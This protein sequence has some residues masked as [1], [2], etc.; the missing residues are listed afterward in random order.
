[1]LYKSKQ[2]IQDHQILMSYFP[3]IHIL[4]TCREQND[5]VMDIPVTG[6]RDLE[7]KVHLTTIPIKKKHSLRTFIM[8]SLEKAGVKFFSGTK[9]NYELIMLLISRASTWCGD[10]RVNIKMPSSNIM[11]TLS[12]RG[13]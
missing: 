13:H 2:H 9:C 10:M 8:Y 12:P 4:Q 3:V 11:V 5:C 6:I 1:M 7:Y